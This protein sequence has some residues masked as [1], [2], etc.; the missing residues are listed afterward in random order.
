MYAFCSSVLTEFP[1][2]PKSVAAKQY[3]AAVIVCD[4]PKDPGVRK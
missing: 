2:T 1:K 3:D 4:H